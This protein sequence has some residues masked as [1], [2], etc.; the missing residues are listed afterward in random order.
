MSDLSGMKG[1]FVGI[2][3]ERSIAWACAQAFHASGAELAATWLTQ[4]S[5]PHVEPLLQQ[6]GVSIR[7][8]LDAADEAK[9]QALFEAISQ[10]WGHLD[11]LPHLIAFAPKADLHGRDVDRYRE[12]FLM[13]MVVSCHSFMRMARL[14]EPL[15]REGGSLMTMSYLRG[16][17]VIPN[18]GLMG[19]V[20]A[21]LETSLHY[22]AIELGP[23][24]IQANAIS[25]GPIATRAASGLADLGAMLDGSQRRTRLRRPL[26]IDD[27][28][29]LWRLPRQ[30]RSACH[31]RHDPVR[32]WRLPY[33]QLT[34][35]TA[36]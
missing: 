27:V 11:F 9:L 14:A 33:S 32:R 19:S 7:Q 15:M 10:R 1:L 34:P 12:G 35:D 25:P 21:A 17:E 5:R 30:R 24:D 23:V 3:N 20:K 4:S 8:P 6:L 28:G 13:A 31:H 16:A 26:A 2:A 36:A 29:T 18:F 22:L